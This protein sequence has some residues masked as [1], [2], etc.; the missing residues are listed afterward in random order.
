MSTKTINAALDFMPAAKKPSS[1]LSFLEVVAKG[2]NEGLE[3]AH[4]YNRLTARG[5]ASDAA[6]RRAMAKITGR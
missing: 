5:V 1:I 2:F 6:A 3:A 4:T